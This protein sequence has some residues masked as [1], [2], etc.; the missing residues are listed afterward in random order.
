VV[1]GDDRQLP[2][3]GFSVVVD[4]SD[5]S[6]AAGPASGGGAS[7]N[8]SRPTS[9]DSQGEEPRQADGDG[10]VE[11]SGDESEKTA[12]PLPDAAGPP[13]S[14]LD[15][16]SEV[17]P[18]AFLRTEYRC[19]D[20]AL[21]SYVNERVYGGGLLT[22]PAAGAPAQSGGDAGPETGATDAVRL[23][24][25]P[26][27]ADVVAG[28]ET[29]ESTEA[30]VA[31]V[32][33]L[34]LEHARTR[35]E[36]SLGVVTLG[37][38][39]AE[40]VREAL[41]LA[42]PG[43]P[44]VATLLT[45]DVAPEP[46]FVK[47]VDD[48][49]G[50]TRDAVVLSVGYGRTPHGRVLHRFGALG[51]PG[52]ERRLAVAATRTRRRMTVVSSFGA[53]DLDPARLSAEGPRLLRDLLAAWESAGAVGQPD[54]AAASPIGSGAA[55]MGSAVSPARDPLLAD[56]ATRLRAQGLQ[57]VERYGASASV[58]DLAVGQDGGPL[59]VAVEA[60]GPAYG[61]TASTRDRDRLRVEHLQRLGWTHLRLWTTDVFRDPAREVARVVSVARA[62][63][64]RERQRLAGAVR[65]SPVADWSRV[66]WDGDRPPVAPTAQPVVLSGGRPDVPVGLP[67][68]EYSAEQLDEIV[69]WIRADTLE[70][71]DE[72]VAAVARQHLGFPRR[73]TRVDAAL[74]AAIARVTAA[75]AKGER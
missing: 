74:D 24:V 12:A 56:L 33:E 55:P 34:V 13:T 8:G 16:L 22:R 48:V 75:G 47:P 1:F 68:E 36:E 21:L 70:R 50:D 28:A 73:G 3:A 72:Q 66:R 41:R 67:V 30:E 60:D 25:V 63:A 15:A 7:V 29:V 51:E 14:V 17:L 71:T 57:V 4:S 10:V 39:H 40:R 52:G 18:V 62:A 27:S 23:E 43:A 31:R 65:P 26:G 58:I 64:A 53:A 44:D 42:L 32:V 37:H 49:Q 6:A 19:L 20:E 9:D 2:P 46:F 35:P 61:A 45:S 11:P 38:R 59:L 5:G 69:R 54:G